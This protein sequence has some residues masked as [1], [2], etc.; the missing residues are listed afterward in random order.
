MAK[1]RFLGL[2]NRVLL[3][4]AAALLALSYLSIIVNPARF[5]LI[6]IAGIFFLPLAVLNIVLFVW[7]LFRKS[8][9]FIIPLLALVPA[10]FF[11]G[12]FIHASGGTA[13]PT[14]NTV[15]V[16]TWNVGRFA[17]SD[18]EG[19]E[20]VRA[21]ADS[22]FSFIESQDPDIVCIQEIKVED[23]ARIKSYLE[24][25]LEGY[26]CEY[27]V[28]PD[29][30]GVFGNATFSK[31]PVRNSGNLDFENSANLA[32][33]TDYQVGDKA[34]RIYNCHFE[35]YNISF[36]G[37]IRSLLGGTEEDVVSKTGH[38]VKRSILRRPKQVD[39]VL[40]D[41]EHCPVEAFVCGDFNDTPMSYTY[42]RLMRGRDDTFVK[43]GKGFAATYA[44]LW[45]LLRLD[46]ILCPDSY[47]VVSHETP[48]VKL[49]DHYPVI[50]E[51]AL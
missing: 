49:S 48:R 13:E 2:T 5:W 24:K 29:S 20:T 15:K 19:T 23:S 41:I 40:R 18:I 7:A 50:T 10:M 43:G 26:Y 46:Y 35:S 8:K 32:M 51:I 22:V 9:A 3:V 21:C 14:E 37:I 27:Y 1:T 42:Y 34:I 25:C 16:M 44:R 45:P 30:K 36:S 31:M 38:K 33:F 11:V 47:T 28:Y 17:M 12:R 4:I 39:Q 6:S